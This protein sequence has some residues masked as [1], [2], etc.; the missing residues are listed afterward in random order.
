MVLQCYFQ[1]Q[2]ELN[3]LYSREEIVDVRED[4]NGEA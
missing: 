3:A 4:E 2:E 1:L